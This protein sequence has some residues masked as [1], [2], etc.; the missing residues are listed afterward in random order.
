MT[1]TLILGLYFSTLTGLYF[2]NLTLT[3]TFEIIMK[4]EIDLIWYVYFTNGALSRD[5]VLR[6][7]TMTFTLS[8][9]IHI[10]FLSAA[11]CQG[12]SI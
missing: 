7:V 12:F 5:N 11:S 4:Q 8:S 6:S 1:V 3:M 9:N 10:H 2:S